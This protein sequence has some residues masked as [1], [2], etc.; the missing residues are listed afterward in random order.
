MFNVVD[1]FG[2]TQH[3][4]E[5]TRTDPFHGT[6]NTLDLIMTNRPSSVSYTMVLPGISDHNAAQIELEAQSI[7]VSKKPWKV[8]AYSKVKWDD[9]KACMSDRG[10]KIT[11]SSPEH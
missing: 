3:I 9:F 1:D 10:K 2:L 11:N 7:R 5:P 4:T 6:S 8:P